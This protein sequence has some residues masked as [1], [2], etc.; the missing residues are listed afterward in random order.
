MP[1]FIEPKAIVGKKF[2]ALD[3]NC[4]LGSGPGPRRELWEKIH[5]YITGLE[6]GQKQPKV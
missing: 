3:P 1:M 4:P 5:A 6:E 2:T